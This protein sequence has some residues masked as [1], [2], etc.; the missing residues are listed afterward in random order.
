MLIPIIVCLRNDEDSH[1]SDREEEQ[2]VVPDISRVFRS[3]M[4]TPLDID[5]VD[6]NAVGDPAPAADIAFDVPLTFKNSCQRLL[7][8]ISYV[9]TLKPRQNQQTTSTQIWSFLQHLQHKLEAT[10]LMCI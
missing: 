8:T 3:M 4:E 7:F 2:I 1:E 10:R 9:P 6:D 5:A